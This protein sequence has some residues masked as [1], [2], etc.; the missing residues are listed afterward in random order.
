M[1]AFPKIE[2]SSHK[3]R[4]FPEFALFQLLNIVLQLRDLYVKHALHTKTSSLSSFYWKKV[5]MHIIC[6]P[7]FWC[8]C[9]TSSENSK[10]TLCFFCS[11]CGHSK[12]GC[13]LLH[14]A[15]FDGSKSRALSPPWLQYLLQSCYVRLHRFQLGLNEPA[16]GE[17]GAGQ[18]RKWE[19][20]LTFEV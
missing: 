17:V 12:V 16:Q 15:V 10:H 3:N 19:S 11:L 1:R 14:L 7:D 13:F 20:F 5:A 4:Y 2:S 9:K 8:Y 6:V 18:L